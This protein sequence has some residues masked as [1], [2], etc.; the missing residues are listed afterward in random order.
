MLEDGK[1]EVV[2]DPRI[3]CLVR[4]RYAKKCFQRSGIGIT[5]EGRKSPGGTM[6]GEANWLRRRMGHRC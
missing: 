3:H 2:P 5:I 6:K 1:E 4:E